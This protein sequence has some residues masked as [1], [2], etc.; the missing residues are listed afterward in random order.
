MTPLCQVPS[1]G[2]PEFAAANQDLA[3][4]GAGTRRPL[5]VAHRGTIGGTIVD[6]T[7]RSVAAAVAHRAD[8]VE[9]DVFSSTDGEFFCFHTGYEGLHFGRPL[10]LTTMTAAEI[11]ELNYSWFS[12]APGSYGV[13]RLP[14][15]LELFPTTV[16]NID[17]SWD[18]W[19]T[20]LPRLAEDARPGRLLLKAKASHEAAL[21]ALEASDV[22]FPFLGMAASP[23]DVEAFVARAGINLVGVELVTDDP[24]SVFASADYITELHERGLLVWANAL[25]LAGHEVLFAGFD[26][27]KSLLQHP[28]DGWGGLVDLGVDFIQTDFPLL[29]ATYLE[30]RAQ[31]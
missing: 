30:R 13:E 6:N 24:A 28:D 4:I 19:P 20:L 11:G 15:V 12:E 21:D 22:P 17:R 7:V 8:V 16:F 9:V 1:F 29:L 31:T 18:W 26:D 10:D 25:N 23:D 5:V 14:T 3:R 2:R 27:E